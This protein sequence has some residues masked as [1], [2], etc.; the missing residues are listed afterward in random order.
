MRYLYIIALFFLSS[1]VLA[2][3]DSTKLLDEVTVT[4][5][6]MSSAKATSLHLEAY[7]LKKLEVHSPYNLSDALSK[8]PGISQMSTGNSISKP[9]IRGLYG[10]RILILFSGLRFDNQQFQDEHG[11]GLS[12]IGIDR[13][14]VIKGPASSLYGTDAI[15]GIINI[16]EE[17]GDGKI[18]N[19]LDA[20]TRLYSNSRGTL[21]DIGF[22]NTNRKGTWYRIRA[23]IER[24]ADYA[25]GRNVR[26]LNSR[27]KGYYFKAG[28]GF[29]RNNWKMENAY[30][31]SYNQFGFIMNDLGQFFLPDA[32]NTSEMSGPHHNVMLHIFSSQNT[33]QLKSSLLKINAGVQSNKR[34]EDEGGG[35]ISLNMHL[36]SILEN[37]KWKKNLGKKTL[38]VINQQATYENNTNLGKRILIPDAHF[39]E[40][41]LSAFLRFY[42]NKMNIEV[43][44]GYNN[45][46]ITTFK[47]GHLN[48]G[49]VNTPDLT[50]RPF[51]NNRS[52]YNGILGISYNP[53]QWINAK[54]NVSTGNRSANLAELSSNGLHEGVYRCEIGDPGLK[55]EQNLN[56]D[57]TLEIDRK[58]W[59]FSASGYYNQF[60]NYIYL[61]PTNENWNGFAVFRY[62]QKDAKIYGGELVAIVKPAKQ[63][64]IK[65]VFSVTEGVLKQESALDSSKYLPFIPANKSSTSIKYEHTA[66]GKSMSWYLSPEVDY[67][68]AQ[69]H[70]AL[71]ETSTAAYTLVNVN[72]GLS[73][74]IKGNEYD[75][76]LSVRNLLDAKYTDHLSRLKYYGLNNQGINVVFTFGIKLAHI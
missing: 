48:D 22:R 45:K 54:M 35:A 73:K 57:V 14:E 27:N 63:L 69:D 30:N 46:Q 20:S 40:N 21:T 44:G 51:S 59:F 74:N 31:F 65:E 53:A 28:Y 72:A 32:R 13:I 67:V 64:E 62:T 71:F 25:S 2:Q 42:F 16:I 34:E 7:S 60:Q 1:V 41:N 11:L 12:Q 55:A 49:N 36:L 33:I 17:S 50:M 39:L 38:L 76:K 9:V 15:G 23:G 68:L 10:N 70:P 29:S 19:M 18:G 61:S 24:H 6:Q 47:T 43:G 56:T 5:I 58:Q 75:C 4:G 52:S 26:V 3:S 66:A 8:V 37:A